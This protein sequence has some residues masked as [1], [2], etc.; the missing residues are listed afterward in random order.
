MPCRC[1]YLEPSRRE[2]EIQ[3]AA[4][5]LLYV[6]ENLGRVPEP[7]ML[8]ESRNAYASE[9]RCLTELCSVLSSMNRQEMEGI[10]YNAH[11]KTARDLANWW[12]EHRVADK[13]RLKHELEEL[14][15]LG[16]IASALAKLTDEER[17]ALGF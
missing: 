8:A 3:R 17:K 13:L 5:L 1:D 9:E 4:Q 16:K 11:D 12:E 14:E 10:V 6:Y 15:R 2:S 7:W